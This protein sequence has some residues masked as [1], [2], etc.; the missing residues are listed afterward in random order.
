MKKIS[1]SI[2]A[3]HDMSNSF[4]SP[5]PTD[6]SAPT[7]TISK[8]LI[9]CDVVDETEKVGVC[10][11]HQLR[12]GLPTNPDE[13]TF[14][15]KNPT[16]LT[17]V[18]SN[19]DRDSHCQ[20]LI[21][22]LSVESAKTVYV[23]D[24]HNVPLQRMSAMNSSNCT[25]THPLET[26]Y[27]E[28]SLER[29]R[30][31]STTSY[32]FHR[33]P[34]TLPNRTEVE[35][36]P[37]PSS[38]VA[39]VPEE[40]DAPLGPFRPE[41]ALSTSPRV[42]SSKSSLYRHHHHHHHRGAFSARQDSGSILVSDLL[43]EEYSS[44]MFQPSDGAISLRTTGVTPFASIQPTRSQSVTAIPSSTSAL[45][46]VYGV[47]SPYGVTRFGSIS[48]QSTVMSA[49]M[50]H[51]AHVDGEL[52]NNEE[53][54]GGTDG[55]HFCSGVPSEASTQEYS[56]PLLHTPSL[57]RLTESDSSH[58]HNAPAARRQPPYPSNFPYQKR[59]FSEGLAPVMR[60]M[61]VMQLHRNNRKKKQEGW[62]TVSSQRAKFAVSQLSSNLFCSPS[63][64]PSSPRP[65]RLRDK[66]IVGTVE[67]GSTVSPGEKLYLERDFKG[68]PNSARRLSLSSTSASDANSLTQN[69]DSRS[70]NKDEDAVTPEKITEYNPSNEQ[71]RHVHRIGAGRHT[72]EENPGSSGEH[73][74]EIIRLHPQSAGCSVYSTSHS[75]SKTRTSLEGGRGFHYN[76]K[77]YPFPEQSHNSSSYRLSRAVNANH[78][79][80]TNVNNNFS[81]IAKDR[82]YRPCDSDSS[83][84][85]CIAK[86]EEAGDSKGRSTS[87]RDFGTMQN[88]NYSSFFASRGSMGRSYQ[89]VDIIADDGYSE[90][91]GI[92]GDFSMR[93]T[94]SCLQPHVFSA[95]YLASFT[96]G[97]SLTDPS[98]SQSQ[99]QMCSSMSTAALPHLPSFSAYDGM[100]ANLFAGRGSSHVA[101]TYAPIYPGT[102]ANS[103]YPR[104]IP[105]QQHHPNLSRHT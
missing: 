34:N 13:S 72:S 12:D 7:R 89:L 32:P 51:T 87:I 30:T 69:F 28:T 83:K 59:G 35:E 77:G 63:P 64:R 54:N 1:S 53:R 88:F 15:F 85:G 70:L 76:M 40:D 10:Y 74:I 27:N 11:S 20:T 101:P 97:S 2:S 104:W 61:S 92:R 50:E 62:H 19:G 71:H 81:L 65:E 44:P 91:N 36:T 41:T 16:V 29:S 14:A 24:D 60:D 95:P 52:L 31:T 3:H 78:T 5:C 67:S 103:V 58:H 42:E 39:V 18:G 102:D 75:A 8:I 94:S 96:H 55:F 25:S 68:S 43:M 82:S 23:Q 93:L 66:D 79:G 33:T 105:Q 90:E 38:A 100:D 56:Y 26:L 98:R 6:S 73:L 48:P 86:P 22:C 4:L 47:P 45:T 57:R 37:S 17:E 9:P 21:P 99:S 49:R 46:A 80:N 84:N